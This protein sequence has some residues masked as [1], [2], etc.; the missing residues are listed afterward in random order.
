MK[1]AG[2][3]CRLYKSNE[4]PVDQQKDRRSISRRILS[5]LIM[6]RYLLLAL[7]VSAAFCASDYDEFEEK[8]GTEINVRGNR[9]VPKGRE[10]T[11]RL[12]PAPPPI[13]GS[14]YRARPTTP[15]RGRQMVQKAVIPDEGGC[16][17][18]S[19]EMG[20][21]CPNG[22][23]L[24]T[25]F[26]K[27]EKNIRTSIDQLKTDV[28]GLSMTSDNI[29]KYVDGLTNV[30]RERQKLTSDNNNVIDEYTN[31]V[32]EQHAFV[33]GNMDTTIPSS[34]RLLR[35]VL[36]NLR[37]KIQRLEQ[38]LIAQR[39][40]CQKPCTVSC[41]IPVVSGKECEDI[42]R[43][44][45]R[46]SEMYLIQPDSF[47]APYKVY[48]D[49]EAREGGW[50]VIQNR[51]DGSVDFGRRW[52]AYRDGFGN[53]ALD[54]KKGVCDS[55]GEFWL[56]NNRISQLTKMGPTEVLFEMQD[57]SGNTVSA[58]YKQFTIQNEATNYMVA[59]AGYDGTAGNAL[60]EG[61]QQLFGINRTMT[62]HNGMMFSTSDRDNDKW[63]PGDP[64]KQCSKE[65][66]GGWWYNR[67]HS[68]NPNGRYY[69]GGEYTKV[70]AKHGTDD[71]VVWMNWKGSWY[72]LKAINMKIRPFFSS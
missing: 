13:S 19:E 12:Q 23:E 6:K 61:A 7:F 37:S 22:C 40:Y 10:D 36:E 15:P 67:C 54:G 3:S 65:D 34:I 32:D 24:K 35:G 29:Y 64:T 70:M 55:P 8:P 31:E 63:D 5:A 50:T 62:I 72:S 60:L 25:N 2:E 38:T 9:P 16:V 39:D 43:K 1:P 51:Q 56:G 47:F 49:M 41:N 53:I 58:H 26:L 59:I 69:W 48:C 33:K 20:L 14:S 71:G 68:A 57:W 28:N 66:G 30:V 46:T 52:D 18:A 11:V 42:Y 21:L 44:G 4:P 27:Q 45:G 17:H